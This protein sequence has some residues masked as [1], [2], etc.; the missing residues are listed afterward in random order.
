[1]MRPD[2]LATVEDALSVFPGSQVVFDQ[3][4]DVWPPAGGWLPG[5]VPEAATEQ[6]GAVRPWRAALMAASPEWTSSNAQTC[7]RCGGRR[8]WRDG[9][10]GDRCVACEPPSRGSA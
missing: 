8:W 1:M 10:A 7:L 5:P 4:P 3:A 2:A 9:I 6:P